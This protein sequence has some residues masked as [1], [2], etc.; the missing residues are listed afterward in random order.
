MPTGACIDMV[1]KP[2]SPLAGPRYR[3]RIVSIE[4][5]GDAGVAVLAEEDYL[6]CDFVD[7]F[8][9]ARLEGRWKIVNKTY[10]HTGG[11]LPG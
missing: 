9:M 5:T 3:A 11:Q 6:G 1:G 4:V 2:K 10:A 7:Y 8:S